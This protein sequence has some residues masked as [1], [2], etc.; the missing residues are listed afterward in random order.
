MRISE[1][2]NQ[3][4]KAEQVRKFAKWAIRRIGIS[5]APSINY[6][7][8]KDRVDSNRTFGSTD[9][10]G[11]IWVYLGNRNAADIMR[12]LCHELIHHRQFEI[13]VATDDMDDEQRLAI[14]DEANA[15]AGRLMRE[16]GK[17]HV[18]IYEWSFSRSALNEY[19]FTTAYGS[20]QKRERMLNPEIPFRYPQGLASTLR[21]LNEDILFES[22]DSSIRELKDF[23][24]YLITLDGKKN[25]RMQVG[26]RVAV[27]QFEPHSFHGVIEVRGFKTP[28]QIINIDYKADG[29]IDYVEFSDGSYFPDKEFLDKGQGGGITDGLT[30]LFFS[31][32]DS[33]EKALMLAILRKPEGWEIGTAN[34]K[35]STEYGVVSESRTGSLQ[36]EVS[37]SLPQAY[38]IPVLNSSNAYDQYK[39]GVAIAGARGKKSRDADNITP[40]NKEN[41]HMDK[42]WADNEVIISYDPHIDEIIDTALKAI[43]KDGPN[44]K[45]VI[46]VKGSK[47]S[48]DVPKNSPVKPFRGY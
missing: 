2:H 5:D 23:Q 33:A 27:L 3:Q 17:K 24:R 10:A 28:K 8:D 26:S 29:L 9:S 19:E 25:V 4:S 6:G 32:R 11:N 39:F 38:A 16:Y 20:M 18:E 42:D 31:T 46:G 12:T 30:T 44:S 13:G 7:N 22:R 21:A 34:I 35:E 47:E 48:K 43:G 36:H 14:E 40:F 37:D 45:R 1:I 15:L 41:S